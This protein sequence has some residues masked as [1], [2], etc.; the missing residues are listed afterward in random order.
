MGKV[1]IGDTMKTQNAL[2]HAQKLAKPTYNGDTRGETLRKMKLLRRA[3][4]AAQQA[5]VDVELVNDC[6]LQLSYLEISYYQTKTTDWLLRNVKSFAI[7]APCRQVFIQRVGGQ[8]EGKANHFNQRFPR[9]SRVTWI[10]FYAK[11][12]V[13]K[14]GKLFTLYYEFNGQEQ[15]L[16][17]DTNGTNAESIK[18]AYYWHLQHQDDVLNGKHGLKFRDFYLDHIQPGVQSRLLLMQNEWDNQ[19]C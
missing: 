5:R 9:R 2:E 15:C 10:S 19:R 8:L 12:T 13:R 6:C 3:I 7:N 14:C 18:Q 16:T 1:S 17:N 11:V 4:Q